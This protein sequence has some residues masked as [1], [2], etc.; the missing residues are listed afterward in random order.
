MRELDE[1]VGVAGD[2]G[3]LLE[4]GE[5][6]IE[7]FAVRLVAGDAVAF[8]EDRSSC[9]AR[10]CFLPSA[11]RCAGA[12]DDRDAR[13][14]RFRRCRRGGRRRSSRRSCSTRRAGLAEAMATIFFAAA[15]FGQ[16][17]G[18]DDGFEAHAAML[19]RSRLFPAGRRDRRCGACCSAARARRRRGRGSPWRC[20]HLA[21]QR[22]IDLVQAPGGPEG[23][24]H[25][26]LV[27][28]DRSYR[29]SATQAFTAGSTSLAGWPRS[30]RRVR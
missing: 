15:M 14:S 30:S 6:G 26:V 20:E 17:G 27:V 10:N 23:F 16:P 3:A 13:A 1:A 28:R 11:L 2:P 19:D 18:G 25:V 12:G 4:R 7:A 8:A 24:E 9:P 5:G 21:Q 22:V 29:A